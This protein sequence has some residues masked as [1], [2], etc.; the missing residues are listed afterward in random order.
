MED[1]QHQNPKTEGGGM[2]SKIWACVG[3]FFILVAFAATGWTQTKYISLLTCSTA[4]TWYPIGGGLAKIW[5]KHVPG[6]NATAETSG[7]TVTNVR[8]IEQGKSDVAIAQNDG[9]YFAARGEK[10]FAGAKAEKIR[11]MFM[12]YD[13]H[14]HVATLKGKGINTISDL[15]GKKVRIGFP[16]S[17]A[18]DDAL[19]IL[20]AYGLSMADIKPFQM[21]F[22]DA[23]EQ[24]KDGNIDALIEPVSYPSSGFLDLAHTRDMMLLG[25]DQDKMEAISKKHSFLTPS[26]IPAGSY[27][28][29]EKDIGALAVSIMVIASSDLSEDL[30][31]KMT[32][33]TFDHLDVLGESHARGKAV[34]LKTALKGMPLPLHPGAEKYYR[35][36]GLIK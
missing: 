28:G 12:L 30:V 27:K 31:Y 36:I 35:E 5:N 32:K 6:V 20:E 10:I 22:S 9:V 24:I 29:Q 14:L 11:G 4:G 18:T 2:R 3:C 34:S 7:C 8:L 16:G 19:I 21:S 25:V 26:T 17:V 33:A 15:R 13:D 1:H 23:F